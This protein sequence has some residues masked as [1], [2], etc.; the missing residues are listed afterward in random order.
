MNANITKP[1]ESK[2]ARVENER[3]TVRPR[4]DVFENASEYLVLADLPGAAKDAIDV[5]FEAGELRIVA[6]RSL[7]TKGVALAEEARPADYERVFAMP[8]GVDPEK[9]E[10][11]LT[12]GVL[13]VHLPKAAAKRPHRIDVRAS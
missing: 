5:Q 13:E 9:I 12:N 2:P 1:N 8:E 3:P 4:V 7:G 11:K 10:A 6:K